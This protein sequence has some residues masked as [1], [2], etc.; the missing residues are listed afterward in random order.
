MVCK[1]RVVG[2]TPRQRF[3]D[4]LSRPPGRMLLDTE[5]RLLDDFLPHLFGYHLLQV[6]RLGDANLLT[7]GKISHRVVV[8]TDGGRD[9]PHPCL[10]AE[11][12]ALPIASD[13]VDVII[14]P[15][16]L[17][18]SPHMQQVIKE[19]RR[20]LVAEGHLLIFAFNPASLIG[21]WHLL[22]AKEGRTPWIPCQGGRFPG[23][24][25]LRGWIVGMGFDVISTKR[26]FFRPP[27]RIGARMNHGRISDPLRFLDTAGL[28]FW[29]FFSGAYLLA[30]KKRVT[31]LTP[32]KS[33]R[34]QPKR[35]LI[36]VGLG[37]SSS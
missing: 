25:R 29:P 13:S 9:I 4:W 11:S 26:Y 18:F 20:V 23:F 15:H 24:G 19:A 7:H 5:A 17:E 33:L 14:L 21:I 6:G 16:V 3:H 30:A 27:V 28:R 37:E 34:R 8:E 12:D 2:S 35:S 22:S 1:S 32:R 36:A 31:T 10:W